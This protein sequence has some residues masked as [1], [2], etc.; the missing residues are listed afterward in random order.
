PRVIEEDGILYIPNGDVASYGP[1]KALY[2]H[3]SSSPAARLPIGPDV[4]IIVRANDIYC[5]PYDVHRGILESGRAALV[6]NTRW[7][8]DGFTY[9]KE[10]IVIPPML[11]ESPLASWPG[12]GAIGPLFKVPGLFVNGSGVSKGFQ[13]TLDLWRKLHKL[14]GKALKKAKLV[15]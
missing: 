11:D 15:L 12:E 7:Q 5:A 3:R 1:T 6:T 8:A 10:K 9:A 2:L 13:A 4:R 14:H